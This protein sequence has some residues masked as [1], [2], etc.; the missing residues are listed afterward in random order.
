MPALHGQASMN[1]VYDKQQTYG[2]PD[3]KQKLEKLVCI[4][5]TLLADHSVEGN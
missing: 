5:D 3:D 2:T 1:S 4:P